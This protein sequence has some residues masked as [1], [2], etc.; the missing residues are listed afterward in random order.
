MEK[1]KKHKVLIV[2][3][4]ALGAMGLMELL[5]IW[6]FETCGPAHTGEDAIRMEDECRPHAILMDVRIRGK[7][8]GIEAAKIIRAKKHLPIIFLSGY[9]EE[10]EK[11]LGEMS[12]IKFLNKPIDHDLLKEALD[13]IFKKSAES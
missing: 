5:D 13:D 2:E 6:G 12:S 8:N 10:V 11:E 9:L 1:N 3:D 4:E 7:M